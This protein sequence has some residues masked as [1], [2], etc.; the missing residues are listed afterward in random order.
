MKPVSE[1]IGM[2]SLTIK[3]K[4]D[5]LVLTSEEL[6][7]IRGLTAEDLLE[8]ETICQ[9]KATRWLEASRQVKELATEKVDA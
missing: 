5:K 3:L 9:A 7:M 6:K 2:I 4:R 1:V 8:V